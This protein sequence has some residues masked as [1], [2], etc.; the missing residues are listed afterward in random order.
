[1]KQIITTKKGTTYERNAREKKYDTML[2]TRFSSE[3]VEKLKN[4]A[5]DKGISLSTFV[6]NILEDYLESKGE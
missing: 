6:R 4:I 5:S 1:M 2:W 3:N